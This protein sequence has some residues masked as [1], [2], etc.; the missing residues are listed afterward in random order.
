MIEWGLL[1]SDD[2]AEL[3]EG[4]LLTKMTQHPP[5]AA[6]LDYTQDAQW[7]RQRKAGASASRN[8]LN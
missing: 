8:R 5:H 1:T 3:I 6:A 7:P 4:M 2:R